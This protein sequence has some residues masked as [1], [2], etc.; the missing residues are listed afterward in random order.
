[1]PSSPRARSELSWP[2]M[3]CRYVSALISQS[4]LDIGSVSRILDSIIKLCL[5]FCRIV[6]Q[7]TGISNPSELDFIAEVSSYHIKFAAEE[8]LPGPSAPLLH[9]L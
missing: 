4:F 5:Q 8:R 9:G 3:L 6:E 7:Q 1:M 2:L